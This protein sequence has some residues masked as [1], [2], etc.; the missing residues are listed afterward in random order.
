M[1]LRFVRELTAQEQ[2]DLNE[3]Y[4][5]SQAVDLAHRCHAI[6]L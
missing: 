4:K 5:T 2:A 3:T 1:P 6:L